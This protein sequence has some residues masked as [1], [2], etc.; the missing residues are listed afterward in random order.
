RYFDETGRTVFERE[1]GRDFVLSTILKGSK[2]PALAP[3]MPNVAKARGLELNPI[4]IADPAEQLWQRALIFPE[5]LDRMGWLVPA[6]EMARRFP[7]DIM[8]GSA[9]SDIPRALHDYDRS[10][11]LVVTHTA[12]LYQVPLEVQVDYEAALAAAA[13][14][15][16]LFEIGSEWA[17]D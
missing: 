16:Q 15:F 8:A 3:E 12:V 6:L 5:R 9:G 13:R 7:P 17:G 10:L 11:P 4:N 14:E 2:R 1:T